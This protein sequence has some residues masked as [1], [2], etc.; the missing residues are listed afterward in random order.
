LSAVTVSGG[1]AKIVRV[2]CGVNVRD[3]TG[4]PS[5]ALYVDGANDI[6]ADGVRESR[7]R[8]AV[9]LTGAGHYTLDVTLKMNAN[10]RIETRVVGGAVTL[11]AGTSAFLSCARLR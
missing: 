10:A 2:S 11:T 3:A 8:R 7:G 4:A 6:A 5:L 9:R 1:D